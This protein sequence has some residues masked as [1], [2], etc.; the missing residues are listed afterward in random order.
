MKNLKTILGALVITALTFTSCISDDDDNASFQETLSYNNIQGFFEANS[1]EQQNFTLDASSGGLIIGVYRTEVTFPPNAFVD[2][3][4][5]PVTGIINIALKEIFDPSQMILSNK[6]TNAVN[7]SSEKTFLLSE[8]ETEVIVSQNGDEVQLAVGISYEIVV[9]SA[10]GL[11]NNMLPFAG[12]TSDNAGIVWNATTDRGAGSNNKDISYNP[13]PSSYIYSAYNT[14]WTNCDKFY[15]DPRP[16]TTNYINLTNSPNATET[17]VFVIFKENN[18]PAVVKYTTSYD[19]GLQSYVDAMPIGLNVSYVAITV[20]NNQL[21][22]AIKNVTIADEEELVMNFELKT[23]Q[24]V[25]D[26]LVA[27]D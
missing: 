11:D 22:M 3:N 12:T 15:S 4:G 17:V 7:F 23:E 6:P 20:E 5:D 24:E 1:V 21:Y 8:G 16:K 26:A 19:D 13:A 9:P 27:L 10:G 25:I 2:D 14:G 18:L